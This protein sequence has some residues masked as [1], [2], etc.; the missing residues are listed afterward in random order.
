[1]KRECK[2]NSPLKDF[3]LKELFHHIH[4]SWYTPYLD[5]LSPKDRSLFTS[6]LETDS[7]YR[8]SKSLSLFLLN[9]LFN[10]T[11]SHPPLPPSFIGEDPLSLLARAPL[12]KLKKLVRLLSLYDLLPELKKVLKGTLLQKIEGILSQEECAYLQQIQKERNPPLFGPIG[13]H[14]WDGD[15][16]KLEEVLLERGMNRLA[17]GLTHSSPD[18]LWYV[19]H[20]FD[21]V[22][23]KKF[24]SFLTPKQDPR[25]VTLLSTQILTGWKT[26]E[27]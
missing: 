25:T 16:E 5:T 23:A 19:K 20:T 7:H 14:N 11:F 12:E 17:K 3:S 24:L 9:H 6:A 18:L 13:L 2:R 4:S 8:L 21:R 10:K 1:M 22:Q 27:S 15:I 26:L